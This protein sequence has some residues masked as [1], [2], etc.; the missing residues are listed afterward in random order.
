M[1][2][3]LYVARS[4]PGGVMV[5]DARSMRLLEIIETTDGLLG[6]EVLGDHAFVWGSFDG[7]GIVD[8]VRRT[9]RRLDV[10]GPENANPHATA[11]AGTSVYVLGRES[12]YRLAADGGLIAETPLPAA[13]KSAT[14]SGETRALLEVRNGQALLVAGGSL[15]RVALRP[16]TR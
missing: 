11:V 14:R 16:A 6:V 5:V 1:G 4:Y 2:D 12:I 13:V 9:Y 15:V 3:R 7:M 8:L 10:H